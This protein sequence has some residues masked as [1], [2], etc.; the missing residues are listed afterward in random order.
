LDNL[1]HLIMNKNRMT[2]LGPNIFTGLPKLTSLYLDH[3]G[4]KT[5]HKDAFKG[6][7]GKVIQTFVI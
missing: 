2:N 7:E 4:I 1:D 3:N 5:I 6:L